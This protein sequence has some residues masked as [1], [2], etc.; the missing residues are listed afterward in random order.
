L[1]LGHRSEADVQVNQ[2]TACSLDLPLHL[3]IQSHVGAAET[4]DRLLGVTDDE[5]FAGYGTDLPPVL[6]IR[7]VRGEQHQQLG[8]K[9]VGVLEF[10]DE[11]VCESF[12]KIFSNLSIVSNQFT[13]LQQ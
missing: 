5:D 4:V 3:F 13:C 2:F 12:L 7:I 8:L 10:I 9:R 6:F 1:N 11:D